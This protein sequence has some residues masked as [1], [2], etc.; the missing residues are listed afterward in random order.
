M[1]IISS[2]FL[3]WKPT[4]TKSYYYEIFQIA[5][6]LNVGKN[7]FSFLQIATNFKISLVADKTLLTKDNPASW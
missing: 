6:E 5:R 1:A 3:R 2:F 7:I 4:K